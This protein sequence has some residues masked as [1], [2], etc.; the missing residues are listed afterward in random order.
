[1]R[2]PAATNK[3]GGLKPTLHAFSAG[4]VRDTVDGVD[5]MD[6]MDK[7]DGIDEKE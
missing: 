3:F 6:G 4:A 5:G 7:M 1:M 2:R